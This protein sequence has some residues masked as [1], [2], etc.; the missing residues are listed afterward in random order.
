M[1]SEPVCSLII[2][3]LIE[4]IKMNWISIIQRNYVHV[5]KKALVL[6]MK[7]QIQKGAVGY[8]GCDLLWETHAEP[9]WK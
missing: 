4:L 6:Q 9:I 5:F 3:M 7:I 2:G 8:K 1:E